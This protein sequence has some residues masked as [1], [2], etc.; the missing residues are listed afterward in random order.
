MLII[1]VSVHYAQDK[2]ELFAAR[3]RLLDAL[4]GIPCSFRSRNLEDAMR[5]MEGTAEEVDAIKAHAKRLLDAIDQTPLA[6]MTV[7]ALDAAQHFRNCLQ[8]FQEA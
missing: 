7:P 1:C 6:N 3:K 4:R 2:E 5:A 8:A